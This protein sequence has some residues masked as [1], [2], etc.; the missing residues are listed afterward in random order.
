MPCTLKKTVEQIIASGNDYRIAV[1]GNQPKLFEHLKTQF[2]Q[3]AARSVD[4]SFDRS[5]GRTMERRVSVL[6]TVAAI[7]PQWVGVQRL[8]Q[9]ERWGTRGNKRLSET[10]FYISSLAV[11][12]AEVAQYIQQHWHVENRLYW[13]KDV[14]LQEDRAP[15]CDGNALVNFAIVRTIVVNLFRG[16]GYDSITQAIRRVA[17]DIPLLFSFFQ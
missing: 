4:H 17:H 3:Q 5:H 16:H 11:D 7:D 13:V 15:L 1:K 2:E 14:V 6:D 8:I 10:M 12:A 9:V